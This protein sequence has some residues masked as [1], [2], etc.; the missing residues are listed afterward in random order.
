MMNFLARKIR[1]TLATCLAIGAVSNTGIMAQGD[2]LS[3]TTP[4]PAGR[5]F[6]GSAVLGNNLYMLGGSIN[7]Q[8]KQVPSQ[9]VDASALAPDG[10][11]LAWRR[12][13]PLAVARHYINNSTLVLN[14]TAY[15]LG[16]STLSLN[17]DRVNTVTWSS[18]L[19]DGNLAPWRESKPFSEAGLSCVAALTTAGYVHITGGLSRTEVSSR[20]WSAPVLPDGSIGDWAESSPLPA[21]LWFH[22]A[23]VVGG[24]AYAWGGLNDETTPVNPTAKVYSAPVLSNGRIGEWRAEPADL[25]EAFYSATSA[26]AG[27]YL[28][29][30]SPRYKAGGMSTDIYWTSVSPQGM[31]QW[32]KQATNLPNKL[33]QAAATDYRRAAIYISGGKILRTDAPAPEV[34]ILRL[35]PAALQA[36]EAEWANFGGTGNVGSAGGST[37]IASNTI[38]TT[39]ARVSTPGSLPGFLQLEAA[40]AQSAAN[41]RPMVMYF[42]SPAAADCVAQ[43]RTFSDPAFAALTQRAVF[44]EI[45]VSK[46]PQV[47]QQSGVF[48]VPSWIFFDSMGGKQDQRAGTRTVGEIAS[49]LE[50]LR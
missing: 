5:A 34:F 32:Q 26:V 15:V 46:Y 20:V 45:D 13:T 11:P 39:P 7:E 6:H 41:R 19:P 28:F 49:V 22:C 10:R 3:P 24:R 48:R 23:A 21:P 50:T 40:R 36:A 27:P 16:G 37:S 33:Y 18:P 9:S 17:G 35:S 38:T 8:G 2:F 43:A 1:R 25:P 30:I 12:A 31:R 29:S 44:A 14:D 42:H 4:L 47:A